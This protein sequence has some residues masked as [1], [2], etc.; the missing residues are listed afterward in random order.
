MYILKITLGS[1][2]EYIFAFCVILIEIYFIVRKKPM[3]KIEFINTLSKDVE[4]TIRIETIPKM[5]KT[6]NP[7]ANN[8]VVKSTIYNNVFLGSDGTYKPLKRYYKSCTSN[9]ILKPDHKRTLYL[10]FRYKDSMQE[11][12]Y[13]ID[14]KVATENQ[15][16]ELKKYIVSHHKS[17]N[18]ILKD[19][20]YYT[21]PKLSNVKY[22]KQG[23]SGLTVANTSLNCKYDD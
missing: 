23:N 21:A 2:S 11:T 6:N 16:L 7:F 5:R 19:K 1:I 18:C 3:S 14:G 12:I 15:V 10:L 9:F 13:L 17:S 8:N 20:W 22:I 4:T